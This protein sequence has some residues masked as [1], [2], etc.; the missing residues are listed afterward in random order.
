MNRGAVVCL[1]LAIGLSGCASVGTREFQSTEAISGRLSVRVEANGAEPVKSVSGGFELLGS[2]LVGQLNLSSPLGNVLAQA[3]WSQR[4]AL[5]VTP[6]GESTFSDLDS[7]TEQML[8]E[9][10]PV[11]ALFDWL[12][13]RPWSGAASQ[14][15]APPAGV[16]FQQLGWSVSLARFDEGLI[17]AQRAQAPQVT[18]RAHV[19]RP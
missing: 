3:R 6:E 2:P 9:S 16:G 15:N 19:D 8:G 7:L 4:Q 11:A 13:G 14:V 5:L 10:L 1:A 12:R 17:T 18:V